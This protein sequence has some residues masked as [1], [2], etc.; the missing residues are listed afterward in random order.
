MH[1]VR[2]SSSLLAVVT[3]SFSMVSDRGHSMTYI[4]M[5]RFKPRIIYM[6][7][8]GLTTKLLPF[9]NFKSLFIEKVA[10]KA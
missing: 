5:P 8:M 3:V 4:E 7:T 6:Q 9:L 10:E 1:Q 2:P